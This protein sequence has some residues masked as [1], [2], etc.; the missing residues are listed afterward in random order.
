MNDS[1]ND[2]LKSPEGLGIYARLMRYVRP[3]WA[4][5][6]ISFVGFLL[7]AGT[8]P[9]FAAMIKHVIDTLQSESRQ[10][11]KLLPLLFVALMLVRGIGSFLGNYFLARVSA[12]VVHTLRCDI[13]NH[14]TLLPTAYFDANNSGYMISRITHNVGEVTR[15]TTDSARTFVREGLTVIG[16][17]GYLLYTNWLLSFVF[18]AI[19][20]PVLAIVNYV[21]KRLRKLSRRIQDSVGELTHITSELV[22]GHRIV[23]SFGGESYEQRRFLESSQYNRY[24][25]LK[26]A[27]TNSIQGPVLQ[28]IIAVALAGLM[29]LALITMKQASAGE[30]VAYLSAAFMLPRPFRLLSDANSEVQRGIAA[31]DSLFEV[32]D[33]PTEKDCGEYETEICR[34]ELE[35]RNLW[36]SYPGS[37]RSALRNINIRIPAGKTVALVGASGGGKSTLINLIPR[38]YDHDRGEILLDGIEVKRYA[39]RNLRRHIALVTQHITLFN[40]TIANNIAYGSLTG[41]SREEVL[42]AAEGAYALEFIETL[43]EGLDTGIGEHGIKLSGGQRQRLAI[44]RALLKNA[45]ILILD[46]ATSSLDTESER[47]IQEALK[48]VMHNRTTLVIAH[49]L[50][51]IENSDLILVM[52]NGEIVEQGRH[53]ELIRLQ[54]IYAR[55]HQNV[56]TEKSLDPG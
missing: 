17:L 39:L 41:A 43:P 42:N 1:L 45:P 38:F 55:L 35:F 15:A 30:F 29:Y 49:R 9:L 20:P 48:L 33:Q 31:A 21:S 44:A 53:P 8:Q 50:S 4:L 54:G 28:V 52:E 11:V 27:A 16:L 51:T 24:Q 34:G 10:E 6:G 36:F 19:T 25:S 37:N 5:F 23:R 12:N 32:L 13:F 40:D 26:L 47:Y 3:H 18:L 14:Y 2:K 7:Y 22:G 56:S 46:E